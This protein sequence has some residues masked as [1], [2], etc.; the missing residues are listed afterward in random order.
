VEQ[1]R[2]SPVAAHHRAKAAN[3]TLE[4]S[5]ASAPQRPSAAAHSSAFSQQRH[6]YWD[7]GET[8]AYRSTSK[9]GQATREAGL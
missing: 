9:V 7:A 5:G 6:R 8:F 1:L 4:P 3:A 2:L